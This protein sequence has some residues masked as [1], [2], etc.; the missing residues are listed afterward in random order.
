MCR[1]EWGLD[2]DT[3]NA[4]DA[5]TDEF[6]RRLAAVGDDAWLLPTPCTGCGV[7]Y[8]AAHVIGGNRFAALV[9]VDTT[10]DAIG[11]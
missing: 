6:G 4:L 5:A 9:L 10:S 7:H 3:L 2:V 1:S 8:L 11:V